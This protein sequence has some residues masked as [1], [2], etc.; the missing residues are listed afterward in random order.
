MDKVT[1]KGLS[2]NDYTNTDKELVDSIP[3]L[4]PISLVKDT[5]GWIGKNL[6]KNTGENTT[7][8]GVTTTINAD[9][10]ITL[11]GTATSGDNQCFLY[12]TGWSQ[13]NYVPI[14]ETPFEVGETYIM[15]KGSSNETARLI[16]Y[17]Y[18]GDTYITDAKCIQKD[19]TFTIPQ[20]TTHL[21]CVVRVN[22]GATVSNLTFYPMIR[23]ADVID[24]TYEPYHESVESMYEEEIHGIN[25]LKDKFV[26]QTTNGITWAQNSNGTVTATGTAGPQHSQIGITFIFNKSFNAIFSGCPVGGGTFDSPKYDIYMWDVAANERAKKWDGTTAVDS[27]YGNTDQEVKIVAGRSYTMTLRVF[28]DQTVSNL[29]FK[30]ML[31]KATIEDPTYRPYNEQAIQNQLNTQT[32]VLGAK[33]LMPITLVNVT[34]SGVTFTK[35]DDNTITLNGTASTTIPGRKVSELTPSTLPKGN[36]ILS[37]KNISQGDEVHFALTKLTASGTYIGNLSEANTT[38]NVLVTVD[39]NGYDKLGVIIW[40][41]SGTVLNNY[42]LYPMLRLASDPDDTY[43]PH[44]MTNR[45]LTEKVNTL[46]RE[47]FVTTDTRTT[48]TND[49][50]T[51]PCGFTRMSDANSNLPTDGTGGNVWYDI[52]TVRQSN[53]SSKET[54]GYGF[55]LA[56]QTTTNANMGD[57]YVR[58]VNGGATPSWG[59]WRKLN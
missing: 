47:V 42:T 39:Y 25:L 4:A 54:W 14:N 10:S 35:N 52:L 56:V 30:P 31:R 27:D 2:T 26:S 34:E 58:A 7:S 50:N 11:N 22:N 48:T 5:I 33:N 3:N 43:Q 23:H 19:V 36:Y 9:K 18:N 15:S 45:E 37:R 51:L 38:D 59:T 57:M 16:F 28:T 49:A 20:N 55:Q 12:G 8:A 6:L 41:R 1:G 13:K 32:G 40:I 24:D 21:A 17:F 29:V 53:D 44:A 46:P